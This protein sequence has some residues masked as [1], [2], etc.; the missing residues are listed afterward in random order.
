[1]RAA[2]ALWHDH[3]RTLVA[4]GKRKI[5]LYAPATAS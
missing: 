4:G 3:I 2:L 1:M 5:I